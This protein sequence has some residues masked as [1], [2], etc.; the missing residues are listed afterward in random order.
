MS[1][2][3]ARNLCKFYRRGQQAEVRALED[4]SLSIARGTFTALTGPSGSGKT[5]LLALLGALDGPTRG[6]V[7][8]DG[9]DLSTLSDVGLARCRRRMGF[10][11]QDFALIPDLSVWENI[12]YPLIPRGVPRSQRRRRAE[13]LL[14]R[15]G[16]VNRS[17]ERPQNLSGGEQ[18]RVAFARALVGEPEVLFADEPTSNLD[19][20][21]AQ[22]LLALLRSC[23]AGGQTVVVST[24]DPQLAALATTVC[25]L[26]AG[27]QVPGLEPR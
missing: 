11:F 8:F 16:L 12:T 7:L 4:V 13:T 5:T 14:D 18:Q 15:L 20:A 3:E 19:V 1:F 21:S 25:V 27:R 26:R 6:Q 9:Q 22:E 10:L 2:L 24:H 17:D 23:H